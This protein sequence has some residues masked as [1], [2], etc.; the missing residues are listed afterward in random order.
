[1]DSTE[2]VFQLDLSSDDSD[3]S[4]ASFRLRE[5]KKPEYGADK[6]AKVSTPG[7]ASIPASL[8][9]HRGLHN[10]LRDEYEESDVTEIHSRLRETQL[11]GDSGFMSGDMLSSLMLTPPAGS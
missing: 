6:A 1:M 9:G 3:S 7:N 5:K 11:S 8:K 4:F 2:V 10:A